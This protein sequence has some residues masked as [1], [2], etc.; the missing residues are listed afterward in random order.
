MREE[1][2]ARAG[3][4]LEGAGGG[5]VFGQGWREEG[6]LW[7]TSYSRGYLGKYVFAAIGP[8]PSSCHIVSHLPPSRSLSL[9]RGSGAALTTHDKFLLEGGSCCRRAMFPN[10][11]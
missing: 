5:S 6:V 11:F 2:S 10:D 7:V 8:H 3:G 9:E 4:W 1:I